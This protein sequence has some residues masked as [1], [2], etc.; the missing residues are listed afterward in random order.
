MQRVRNLFIE[1]SCP[2]SLDFLVLRRSWGATC[3]LQD[4]LVSYGGDKGAMVLVKT[5]KIAGTAIWVMGALW[6]VAVD[7][8]FQVHLVYSSNDG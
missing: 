2:H 8:S 6:P 3:G 1:G 4:L 7:I 5:S